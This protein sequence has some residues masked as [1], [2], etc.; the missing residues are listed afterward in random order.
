MISKIISKLTNS[1]YK[2]KRIANSI[3]FFCILIIKECSSDHSYLYCFFNVSKFELCIGK[4]AKLISF[5]V[6]MSGIT[7]EDESYMNRFVTSIR[8]SSP[9]VPGKLG[10]KLICMRNET[11]RYL[12]KFLWTIMVQDECLW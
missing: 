11:I 1:N 6:L 5:P 4:Y 8:A 10:I 7:L 2:Y 9:R 12:V 3:S